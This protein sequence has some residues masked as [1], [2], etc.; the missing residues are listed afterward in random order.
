MSGR[1]YGFNYRKQRKLS[2]DP[3]DASSCYVYVIGTR[4]VPDYPVKIGMT[5]AGVEKRLKGLQTGSPYRLEIIKV[6]ST[7]KAAE[8]RLHRALAS[9]RLN[10]EWFKPVAEVMAAIAEL[11]AEEATK[12]ADFEKQCAEWKALPEHIKVAV[13]GN[14][15]AKGLFSVFDE[16]PPIPDRPPGWVYDSEV[17]S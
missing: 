1:T 13:R 9:H 5:G 10:G 8:R 7:N 12:L 4:D 17:A 16:N 3:N 6:I 11:E 2:R 15:A 14:L